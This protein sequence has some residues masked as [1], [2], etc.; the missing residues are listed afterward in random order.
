MARALATVCCLGLF[1]SFSADAQ[2]PAC[3]K[4]EGDQKKLAAEIL[5]SQHPYDCCD[6][7]ISECLKEKP[8]CAL[9]WRLA[10]NI[11]RRVAAGQDKQKI[12]RGLSRRARSMMSLGAK[13]KIDLDGVPVQ[14]DKDGPVELVMYAC[15]R[16]PFCGQITPKLHEA[17]TKG[18]LKG[19]VRLYFKTFPIRTHEFSK[20]SG[21]AFLA[22]AELG[23]FWEFALY[24]FERF[25][26]F[27]VKKQ[28]EW[29][30]A[31]GLDRA[32]FEKLMDDTDL[33]M[34]LVASKKEGILNKVDATPTF[35]MNGH[36]FFGDVTADEIID[37]AEEAHDRLKDVEHLK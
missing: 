35:F 18:P 2:T 34:R 15:A 33:Q 22:A 21:F 24:S 11:C 8:V 19:K 17:V 28:G 26:S 7:T 25:E 13:A 20:E 31:V 30:A 4:L 10:E 37:V 12:L 27:S 23:R 6:G 36:K 29:A 5:S 32:A 1:W 3:D 16:C 14:G 9:A